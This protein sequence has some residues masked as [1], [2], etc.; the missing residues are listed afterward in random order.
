MRATCGA[1]KGSFGVGGERGRV[2]GG[3]LGGGGVN[4]VVNESRWRSPHRNVIIN[5]QKGYFGKYFFTCKNECCMVFSMHC[6]SLC[7]RTHT[8][9]QM[10]LRLRTL[11]RHYSTDLKLKQID[12]FS[13]LFL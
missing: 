6:Q 10:G 5:K 9:T 7:K 12:Q 3:E 4:E 2:Q 11:K 1:A 8:H 13:A